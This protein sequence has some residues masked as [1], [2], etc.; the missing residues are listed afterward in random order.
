M[1]ENDAQNLSEG[2]IWATSRSLIFHGLTTISRSSASTYRK[3]HS[4]YTST[5]LNLV[6][7]L[8]LHK[9]PKY[10]KYK[11]KIQV[12]QLRHYL[13][14]VRVR[15]LGYGLREGEPLIEGRHRKVLLI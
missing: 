13:L 2:V 11:L 1:L 6:L 15:R 14:R 12:I 5:S 3:Q 7:R 8:R 4:L 9:L 10:R